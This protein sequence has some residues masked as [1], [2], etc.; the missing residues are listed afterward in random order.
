MQY[1]GVDGKPHLMPIFWDSSYLALWSNFIGEMAD[2]YD[3]NPDIHSIGITGGGFAGGTAVLPNYPTSVPYNIG[4]DKAGK[5]LEE[6]LKTDF[7]MNQRQLVTHW[8]YVADI[9]PKHFAAA[10]LNFDINPPTAKRAGEDS[11][12]EISDYLVYRYGERVFLTRMGVK[13]GHHGFDDYRILLKFRNDTLTGLQLTN[14]VTEQ[15]MPKIVKNALDDGISFAEI[16]AELLV[17]TA[18]QVVTALDLFAS[19]IGF[20][21]VTRK[22]NLPAQVASGAPIPATFDFINVGAATALRPQREVDKDIAASYRVQIELRDANGK[23]VLQNVHTPQVPT[24]QW[25]TGQPVT[26][27]ENLKMS[28]LTPG[29][30]T[31]YMS[32]IDPERKR[33]IEILDASAEKPTATTSVALGAIK[34][35]PALAAPAS[36]TASGDATQIK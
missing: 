27:Q 6:V 20:Q 23:I 26:W 15:E 11:L 24:N 4:G 22:A 25:A 2:K 17:S 29:D 1:V 13:D 34:I 18:P 12:D 7:G 28:P 35:T 33:T 10:R 30:Y 32:L 31:A 14:A 36:S 19:H 9:F 21:L 3:K 16:P 8:K 5:S